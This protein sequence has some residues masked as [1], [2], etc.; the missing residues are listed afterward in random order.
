MCAILGV[1]RPTTVYINRGEI[2]CDSIFVYAFAMSSW[3]YR[4][5][6]CCLHSLSRE[7]FINTHPYIFALSVRCTQIP[8]P[9][10]PTR[11][12]LNNN[13]FDLFII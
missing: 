3:G 1:Y 13:I 10:P 5:S 11:Q 2:L 9:T 4:F 6:Q 7:I 12:N 8:P